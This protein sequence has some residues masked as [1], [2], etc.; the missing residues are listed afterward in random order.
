MKDKTLCV[1]VRPP[2]FIAWLFCGW[3]L[4]SICGDPIQIIKNANGSQSD[5]YLV[6][7]V[8]TPYPVA[9]QFRF[10][11]KKVKKLTADQLWQMIQEKDAENSD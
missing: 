4:S 1:Y 3:N 8:E 2:G 10:L 7:V 9:W 6:M 5:G 11:P